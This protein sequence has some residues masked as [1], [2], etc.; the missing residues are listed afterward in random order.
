VLYA[1]GLMLLPALCIGVAAWV[2][3]RLWAAIVGRRAQPAAP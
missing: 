3:R 1:L 2:L